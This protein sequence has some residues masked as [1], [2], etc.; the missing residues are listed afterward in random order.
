M[1]SQPSRKKKK[2]TASLAAA[3]AATA[4]V[5]YMAP[6]I[7][8]TPQ[9]DLALT[10][11]AW[12]RELLTGHPRHFHNMLGMS[13]HVFRILA[14]ELQNHAGLGDTKYIALEEQLALF[15]HLCRTGGSHRDLQ[16]RFQRSPD[17]ISK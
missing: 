13:K 2:L 11:H 14:R 15:L 3:A 10:G 16:K 17:T 12:V 5:I 9:N 7:V 8:K 1:P 6:Q 4:V